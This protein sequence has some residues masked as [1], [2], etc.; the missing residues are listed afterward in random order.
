MVSTALFGHFAIVDE[1][2]ALQIL[3][4]TIIVLEA[5]TEDEL[6]IANAQL[7]A[8]HL[9]QVLS[10]V[11]VEIDKICKSLFSGSGHLYGSQILIR[12]E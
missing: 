4:V 9:Y 11:V 7:V 2:A 3:K 12:W 5:K 1:F 8:L 6:R 10:G